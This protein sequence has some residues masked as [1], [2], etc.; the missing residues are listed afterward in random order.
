[1][2]KRSGR[3]NCEEAKCILKYV[4]GSLSGEE[5]ECPKVDYPIHSE[6]LTYFKKLLNNEKSMSVSAKRI[7]D[8][9]SSISSF[10]VNMSHISY[11]L[12]DFAG[13][14][15]VLSE[16]NLAIVE[17]TTAS[18]NQVNEAIDIT[19]QTLD[20]LSDESKTLAQK[21]DES[22]ALLTEVQTL[23]ENVV[24]DTG[25]MSEKI[26][27]LVDLAVEVGKIVDS[28]QTIAEQTNL[29]ALN[30]A[31]EAAR[32]GEHGR[33]FAVVAQEVRKLAD[34]TKS[35]LEGMRQFVNHIHTAAQEGKESLDSTLTSTGEMS[36]KIEAVSDTVGKNVS[37]LNDVIKNVE[38]IHKSMNGIR[39]SASEINQAMDASSSDA[40]RLSYMTQMI[41][42]DAKESVGFAKEI[43]R[44]D[45]ELSTIA[46]QMFESLKGGKHAVT[47]EEFQDVIRKAMDSHK[48]WMFGLEKIATE[49]RVYPIQTNSL[50][51]AF[52]HFYNAINIDHVAIADDWKR[53]DVVHSGFHSAGDKVINAVKLKDENLTK[54]EYDEAVKLSRQMLN[55]LEKVDNKLE[56]LKREGTSIF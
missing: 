51:C 53:I 39:I 47:N 50:K 42:N 56:S 48:K 2:F 17:E 24:D 1:M 31:I 49:M 52:G 34:D 10:D 33:G 8:I 13:E 5:V 11:Q 21:N 45:D 15:A 18:M 25:V 19:S 7:L 46:S 29:L 32:A 55:L 14:L 9:V 41:H 23:K 35:N 40:E 38:D 30:A 6:V 26:Q 43:S 3:G 27:Q 28:V 44:I 16:S 37:M 36:E 20:N 12:M 4:E 22:M 54:Q